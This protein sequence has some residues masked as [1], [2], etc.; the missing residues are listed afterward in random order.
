MSPNSPADWPSESFC[1]QHRQVLSR[2]SVIRAGA[3]LFG[4]GLSE[5][6][7]PNCQGS[8]HQDDGPHREVPDAAEPDEASQ[9][10]KESSGE[11][12]AESEIASRIRGLIMG[13]VLGDAIGGP[14]EF[15]SGDKIDAVLPGTRKWNVDR[16]LTETER[17]TLA[18]TLKLHSYEEL[19]PGIESYGQWAIKAPAGTVTDDTRHKMVLIRTLQSAVAKQQFPVRARDLARAYIDFTPYQGIQPE[20]ELAKMNDEGFREYRMAA[21]W[22]LGERN[23]GTARPLDRLWSG[24]PNCSG[25][26]MLT[27]LAAAFPGQPEA[28]YR[29][30]Y[31]LDF[32]DGPGARDMACALVAGL[33]AVLSPPATDLPESDRWKLLLNTMRAT[34][35][36]KYSDVPFAGRPLLGWMDKAE[37]FAS[38][39]NGI[40][41]KLFERL[42]KDGQPVYWWDAHFTL[43]VPMTMLFFCE[44]DTLAALHLTLDFGHDTDS[45]AHVLGAMSGAVIGESVFPQEMQTTVRNRMQADYGEDIDDWHTTLNSCAKYQKANAHLVADIDSP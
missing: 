45:Y 15:Q 27:P 23:L 17:R 29:A 21:R 35:P 22:L 36:Y 10:N 32:I 34:D 12:A 11:T 30:A 1:L 19:R 37:E 38:S 33:A 41:A 4:L 31:A 14:V 5:S 39:A 7:L 6:A 3:T 26:M 2:R 16:R 20:G 44:F 42:E 24:I 18:E 40:P 8:W 43:L 9:T 25:Q 28:A 13:G